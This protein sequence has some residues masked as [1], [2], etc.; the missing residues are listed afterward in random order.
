M[1]SFPPP[2][3]SLLISGK[4]DDGREDGEAE[5]SLGL[6]GDPTSVVSRKH[7][8]YDIY[9]IV[10]TKCLSMMMPTSTSMVLSRRHWLTVRCYFLYFEGTSA[11]R[12]VSLRDQCYK[13]GMSKAH[14]LVQVWYL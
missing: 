13:N 4:G 7:S 11:E 2:P 8:R 6:G 10:H 9:H 14:P 1:I 5:K 12:M 3:H